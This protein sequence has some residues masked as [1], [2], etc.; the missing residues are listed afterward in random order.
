MKVKIWYYNFWDH[1]KPLERSY[2]QVLKENGWEFELNEKDPDIV[3]FNAFKGPIIYNGKAKKVGYVTEDLNRFPDLKKKI[4]EKFFDLVIG[5]VPNSVKNKFCKHPLYIQSSNYKEPSKEFMEEVNNY[6]KNIDPSNL[7]FCCLI[8]SHDAYGNRVPMV[9]NLSQID[10]VECPGKLISNVKSFD[11]SGQ[12]KR[13]YLKKFAFNLCPENKAGHVGYVTEK[14]PDAIAS[15]CIPIYYGHANDKQ[16]S[17][18]FNQDRIIRYNPYDR[19]SVIE[20]LKKVNEL[21]NNKEKLIEF[22]RQPIFLDN[23]HLE[24][25]SMFNDLKNKFHDLLN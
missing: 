20:C 6:V 2:I 24:I 13:E 25:E 5:C 16:D 23:A 21:W 9:N 12:T 3:F 22:Y 1:F 11:E 18:I 4:D 10:F 8:S 15:G 19:N 17:R 14:I 7:K